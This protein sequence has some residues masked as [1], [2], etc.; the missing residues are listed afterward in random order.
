MAA[1][2]VFSPGDKQPRTVLQIRGDLWSKPL[3]GSATPTY[4]AAIVQH[5]DYHNNNAYEF[6][7]QSFGPS[8][9]ARYKLSDKMSLALRGDAMASVLAAVNS[10]YAFLADVAN[11]ERFR[12]YDYG[13]GLGSIIEAHLSRGGHNLLS[14]YYRYH[15]IH[16]SNGSIF[17]KT[18]ERAQEGS[19]AD[20]RLQAAGGRLFLPLRKRMGLGADGFVVLRRSRY[21]DPRLKDKDQRNPEVRVYLA[22]D[23][24]RY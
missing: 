16:V 15:W 10:D 20:H 6:G 19:D 22:W 14:L 5:F 4:A 2:Y 7:G 1:T 8:L 3:G 21:S 11:R 12:E 17:N 9:F 13:P 18:D 24:G 23:L